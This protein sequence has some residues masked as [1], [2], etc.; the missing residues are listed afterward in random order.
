MKRQ[1]VNPW[2]D[3]ARLYL[4]MERLQLV[5]DKKPFAPSWS[6]FL[7]ILDESSLSPAPTWGRAKTFRKM[8]GRGEVFWE[9][10]VSS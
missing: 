1:M 10:L 2:K 8:F 5:L 6:L 4:V 9:D 7:Q 3:L